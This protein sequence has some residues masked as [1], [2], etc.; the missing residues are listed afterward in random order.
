MPGIRH[1]LVLKDQATHCIYYHQVLFRL[2]L[3]AEIPFIPNKAEDQP[4][5]FLSLGLVDQHGV[6]YRRWRD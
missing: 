6:G 5:K 2:F 1:F 4:E 3:V